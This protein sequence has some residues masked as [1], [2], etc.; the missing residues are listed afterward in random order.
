MM[1]IFLFQFN[2][3]FGDLVML[4]G[5]AFVLHLFIESP[6]NVLN[7]IILASRFHKKES[8]TSDT[9]EEMKKNL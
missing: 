6:C 2:G 4:I 3:V 5:V 9:M 1:T 8:P 7:K